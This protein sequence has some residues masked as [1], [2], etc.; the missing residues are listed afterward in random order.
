MLWFRSPNFCVQHLGT[1]FTLNQS[2][3]FSITLLHRMWAEQYSKLIS[4]RST[5]FETLLQVDASYIY[6][7]TYTRSRAGYENSGR[8][9][10]WLKLILRYI[11]HNFTI[12]IYINELCLAFVTVKHLYINML[13]VP[14]QLLYRGTIVMWRKM[15]MVWTYSHK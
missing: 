1:L 6:I 7:Y 12:V 15:K 8:L 10:A 4:L 5:S 2:L 3:A 9:L 11:E 14:F 13:A